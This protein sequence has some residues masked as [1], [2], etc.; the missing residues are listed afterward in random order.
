MCWA[1]APCP[2]RHAQMLSGLDGCPIADVFWGHSHGVVE[3]RIA[4]LI[5]YI[6]ILDNVH[7]SRLLQCSVCSH[8]KR[9]C[10][11]NCPVERSRSNRK[12]SGCSPRTMRSIHS[13]LLYCSVHEQPP[14]TVGQVIPHTRAITIITA[15]RRNFIPVFKFCE[16]LGLYQL[17]M[18]C[19]AK[20][21]P[22]RASSVL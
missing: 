9:A 18:T 7:C 10:P 17:V 14:S 20:H 2:S 8:A 4:W 19:F 6:T 11:C 16:Q 13:T 21:G 22:Y 3:S 12:V 15:A 1:K 5:C